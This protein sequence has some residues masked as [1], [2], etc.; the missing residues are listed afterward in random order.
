MLSGKL[1]G[2]PEVCLSCAMS[3]TLGPPSHLFLKEGGVRSPNGM[4][5]TDSSNG[6]LAPFF[7]LLF[8]A[9]GGRLVVRRYIERA[10]LIHAPEQT[11]QEFLAAAAKH[12]RFTPEV[13]ALLKTFLESSDLVKFAGQDATPQL[14]DTAVATAR[15]YISTDAEKTETQNQASGDKNQ[16]PP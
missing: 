6:G 3:V 5:A 15:N 9:A 7:L 4:F 13:L 10:H 12:P 14:A 2:G 11:T 8:A 16:E 1:Y